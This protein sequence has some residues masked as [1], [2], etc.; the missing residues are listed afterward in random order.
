MKLGLLLFAVVVIVTVVLFLRQ[1]T[2]ARR[3]LVLKRAGFIVTALFTLVFVLFVVGDTFTDPG[4][5]K[6]LGLVSAWAIPLVALAAIAWFRPNWAIRVLATLVAALIGISI[7]FAVN[8]E[9]WRSFE[10]RNGPIRDVITFVVAAAVAMLGLKRAAVAGAM[11]L[12][13]GIVPLVVT[14]LGSL[15]GFPSLVIVTSAPF[16]TGV[17]YLLSVAMKGRSPLRQGA[18]AGPEGWLKEA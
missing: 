13:L 16:I 2:P 5:W 1:K 6:A 10:N 17:L 3:A 8:P 15:L 18:E 7:W 4:G 12:V 14:S 9:G 11:L